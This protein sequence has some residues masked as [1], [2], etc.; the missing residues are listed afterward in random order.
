MTGSAP[1]EEGLRAL[2]RTIEGKPEMRR[3]RAR[4]PAHARGAGEPGGPGGPG[5]PTSGDGGAQP[6]RRRKRRWVKRTLLI[7][8]AV[9]VV[10]VGAGAGYAWYL[11][12]RIH[13]I[14]VN[15]LT[16][17]E[18]T[19]KLAN[20]ENILMVGSTTRCGLKKQ[21]KAYGLCTEG[22]TGVNSDVVMILHV[23][24]NTGA[25]S[26]LSL[27]R[28]LFVPNARSTT[29]AYKIDASLAQGPTQLVAAV[30][31]DFAIPIQ[32]YVELT[33]DSFAA[34]VTTLGGITMTFPDELFD[35]ESGLHVLKTGCHHLDGLQALK[36]VRARHLQYWVKGYPKTYP[37]TWPQEAQS[38]LARIVRD[39][40]FLRVLATRVA[41]QGL[42]NPATD[43]SLIDAVAPDLKVDDGLSATDMVD[44]VRAFHST[45][46]DKAPATTLP[47]D[48]DTFGTYVYQG[49][50]MGDVEFP[51]EPADRS[52][53][54]ALLGLSAGDNTMTG[55]PLPGPGGVT[56][57]V[58]NG[59][60]VTGQATQTTASLQSLGFDTIGTGDATAVGSYRETT[61]S[62]AHRTPADVAAAQLVAGSLSGQVVLAYDPAAKGARV[63]VTTGTDFSVDAALPGQAANA[64]PATSTTSSVGTT[65][66]AP[67]SIPSTTPGSPAAV[68]GFAPTTTARNSL[69]SYD[70]RACP[71]GVVGN[72][73]NW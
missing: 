32:H 70:P 33:F 5:A 51:A 46:V 3:G 44:L 59:T 57:S 62:Y 43:V 38:D 16:P 61:V 45:D 68:T 63:T 6:P 36:V 24:A 2:A 41:K 49:E 66:S 13:R 18:T 31:E 20:T 35:R 39:H 65:S 69:S 22:V 21:T 37:Y 15:G 52:S 34:V 11:N 25:V 71:A 48:V 9:V 42:G 28:D 10:A 72:D 50:S 40:E 29:G 55:K 12:G 58:L 64:H 67:T 54:D 60:G 26:I 19:G 7:S 1:N 8:L 27:P 17:G 53:I 73:G 30:E 56:V 23:D 4:G 14:P 47:V